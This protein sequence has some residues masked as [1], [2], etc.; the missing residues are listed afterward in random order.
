VYIKV[1][2]RGVVLKLDYEKAYDKVS[3][4]LLY[5]LGKEGLGESG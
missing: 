3:W 4:D 2:S 5:V 1:G